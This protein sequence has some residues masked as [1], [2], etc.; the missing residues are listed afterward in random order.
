MIEFTKAFKTSDEATH[1]TLEAAQT[2]ELSLLFRTE[3]KQE[4]GFNLENLCNLVMKHREKIVDI[5]ST[6]ASSRPK[7]RRING[8]T[9]KRKAAGASTEPASTNQPEL[10]Q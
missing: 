3:S 7:A 5:L 9:K 2:H 10:K 4:T 6:T 1:A 8:G